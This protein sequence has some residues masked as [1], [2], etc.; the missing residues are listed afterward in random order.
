[1]DAKQ[2]NI[3]KYYQ[4]RPEDLPLCCPLPEMAVWNSHPRVYLSLEDQDEVRCPYCGTLFKLVK[5]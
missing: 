2:A 1:M 3:D 5:N 4:I